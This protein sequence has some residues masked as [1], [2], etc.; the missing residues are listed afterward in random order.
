MPKVSLVILRLWPRLF[1]WME[2]APSRD[3][4]SWWRPIQSGKTHFSLSLSTGKHDYKHFEHNF[5]QPWK[6]KRK[7]LTK[8]IGINPLWCFKEILTVIIWQGSYNAFDKNFRSCNQ[9]CTGSWAGLFCKRTC[10]SVGWW[11][12]NFITPEQLFL[13]EDKSVF[14]KMRHHLLLKVKGNWHWRKDMEFSLSSSWVSSSSSRFWTLKTFSDL[15]HKT[16]QLKNYLQNVK[17]RD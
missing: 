9:P 5:S 11:V 6:L 17:M 3:I 4:Q 2:V 8:S 12:A 1:K 7:L 10:P 13:K 14:E 15:T 16:W